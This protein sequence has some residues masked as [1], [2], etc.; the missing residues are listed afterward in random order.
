[1]NYE[2]V[3]GICRFEELS[4]PDL[5][6][7]IDSINCRYGSGCLIGHQGE[8][9]D[10]LMTWAIKEISS[11]RDQAAISD[12]KRLCTNAILHARRALACLFDWYVARDLGNLCKNPPKTAIQQADFLVAR[13]IIDDLTSRV[14]ARAVD[15]RNVLEHAYVSLD[16][17]TAEDVVEL[18]RRSI[19]SMRDFA[20]P[21]YG[22]WIFGTNLGGIAY[23]ESDWVPLFYGWSEPLV[24]FSRTAPVPW[25]GTV[26]PESKTEAIVRFVPLKKVQR[27]EL[28]TLLQAAERK[29]ESPLSFTPEAGCKCLMEQLGLLIEL[30]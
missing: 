11:A 16:L 15:K 2:I 13:G 17:E 7:S 5:L 12:Q 3:K 23:N 20:K 4:V 22:P 25:I 26:I 10:L 24:V 19:N 9:P 29:D 30:S 18:L 27:L 6:D 28:I 14:L 8:G 1:M 21:E